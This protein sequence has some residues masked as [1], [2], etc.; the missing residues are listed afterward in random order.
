MRTAEEINSNAA[1]IKVAMDIIDKQLQT[2]ENV[3]QKNYKAVFGATNDMMS[4]MSETLRK[5]RV[6]L[7]SLLHMEINSLDE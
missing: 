1:S 3:Y 4:E 5:A 7:N 2:I 6:E